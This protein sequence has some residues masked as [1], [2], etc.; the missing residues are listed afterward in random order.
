MFVSYG[1]AFR[2]ERLWLR[3]TQDLPLVPLIAGC[4]IGIFI[5]FIVSKKKYTA[6]FR[7]DGFAPPEA[8]IIR[9]SRKYIT[10]GLRLTSFPPRWQPGSSDHGYYP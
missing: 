10:R 5:N 7:R 4:L 9:K 3:G 1:F 6:V 2:T 8:R